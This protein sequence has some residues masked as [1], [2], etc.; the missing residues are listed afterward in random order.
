MNADKH[1]YLTCYLSAKNAKDA[2]SAKS[3]SYDFCIIRVLCVFRGY[4]FMN[5]CECP[6]TAIQK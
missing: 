4:L 6:Y 3:S 1:G 5:V 2:K